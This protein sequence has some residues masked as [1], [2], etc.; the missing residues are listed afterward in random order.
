VDIRLEY[1][2]KP[3][4]I[5]YGEWD[6]AEFGQRHEYVDLVTHPE[7]VDQLP[8][9]ARCPHLRD[10]LLSVNTP[11]GGLRTLGCEYSE[12]VQA[13][14]PPGWYKIT[15]YVHIAFRDRALNSP[16][17]WYLFVGHFAERMAGRP[18]DEPILV[19]FEVQPFFIEPNGGGHCV[20]VWVN[21]VT[22]NRADTWTAWREGLELVRGYLTQL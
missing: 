12:G 18:P 4:G 11:E 19:D 16:A 15:S 20:A 8:E 10:F 22:P 17:N 1:N 9:I 7:A 21:A 6:D 13:G 3:L 5:P 14:A 2:R